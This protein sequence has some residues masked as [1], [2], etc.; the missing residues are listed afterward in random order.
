MFSYEPLTLS[1]F[2]R[3]RNYDDFIF[4]DTNSEFADDNVKDSFFLAFALTQFDEGGDSI[5][6]PDYA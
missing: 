1:E 5:E 6:S 3:A 4:P 2:K